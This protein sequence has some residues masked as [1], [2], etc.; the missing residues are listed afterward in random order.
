MAK[1]ELQVATHLH[2]RVSGVKNV[3]LLGA[4]KIEAQSELTGSGGAIAAGDFI[5]S[6]QI[7]VRADEHIEN[8]NTP[9][10]AFE[11]LKETFK[12]LTCEDP[13]CSQLT[14]SGHM[15]LGWVHLGVKMAQNGYSIGK[16]RSAYD[17]LS[18]M[19]SS[20]HST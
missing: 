7:L 10:R 1:I 13:R 19:P 11:I 20:D 14:V 18:W 8:I 9:V 6:A 12:T 2:P 16:L 17:A 5:T 15:L 4:V 3:L